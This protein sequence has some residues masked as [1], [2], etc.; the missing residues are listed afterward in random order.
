MKGDGRCVRM[1]CVV[2]RDKGHARW[3]LARPDIIE[4]WRKAGLEIDVDLRD[5]VMR[6]VDDEGNPIDTY[7][8]W[9]RDHTAEGAHP[10]LAQWAE[11]VAALQHRVPVDDVETPRFRELQAQHRAWREAEELTE[12][13]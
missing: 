2:G 4:Q 9:R 5:E 13:A 7:Y 1:V 8:A 3:V 10:L 6:A 12:P 11:E